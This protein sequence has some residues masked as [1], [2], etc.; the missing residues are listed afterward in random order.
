MTSFKNLEMAAA[1]STHEHITIKKSLFS[2]KAIY[3]PSQSPIKVIVQDYTPIEGDQLEHL[4]NL[5]LN[6]MDA[7]IDQKGK[8]QTTPIG[9]YRLEVC[10]S[11]DHQFCALQL[12]CF[13][14]FTYHPV[15]DAR[16][17]EGED[18]KTIAKLIQ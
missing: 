11:E 10:L 3:T 5:P 17:Y 4:L 12:F 6:K 18:V 16:F 8:P 7:L 15:F 14:D 2:K 13:A 1:V 9:H